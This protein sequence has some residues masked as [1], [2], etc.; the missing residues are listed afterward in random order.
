MTA[1]SSITTC[2]GRI[3]A[4]SALALVTV[5]LSAPPAGAADVGP[6]ASTACANNH[7]C[8]WGGAVYTG[9]F[10]G[11]TVST[12]V[13]TPTISKAVWNRTAHAVRVYVYAGESGSSVCFVPGTQI[14]NTT[15]ASG[16]VKILSTTTC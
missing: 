10:F 9:A 12:D 8:L 2:L 13:L 7:M 1:L 15:L 4:A 5:T 3:L 14:A 6:Q 11:T 16:S